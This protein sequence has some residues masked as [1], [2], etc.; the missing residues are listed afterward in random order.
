MLLKLHFTKNALTLKL[1]LQ[2]TQ[3]LIDVVITNTN[4]HVVFT[5]SLS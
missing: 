4:L 2:S 1:F 5:T 3:R